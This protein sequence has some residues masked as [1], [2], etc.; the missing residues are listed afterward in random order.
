MMYSNQQE[1]LR[2]SGHGAAVIGTLELAER[3]GQKDSIVVEGQ[4]DASL[5]H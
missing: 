2:E 5:E 3:P 4:E 1:Y